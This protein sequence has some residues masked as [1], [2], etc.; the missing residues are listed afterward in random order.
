[1]SEAKLDI[2][3]EKAAH[4]GLPPRMPLNSGVGRGLDT[5]E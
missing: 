1:M 3:R 5:R 2:Q 4:A